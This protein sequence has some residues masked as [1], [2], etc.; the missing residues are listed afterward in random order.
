[1]ASCALILSY[2][3]RG[4]MEPGHE[5]NRDNK[6]VPKAEQNCAWGTLMTCGPRCRQQTTTRN[7]DKNIVSDTFVSK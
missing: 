2:L 5:D 6:H 4:S 1:M 7:T 3:N